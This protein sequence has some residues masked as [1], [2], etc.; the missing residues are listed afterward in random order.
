MWSHLQDVNVSG[1][2]YLST[3]RAFRTTLELDVSWILNGRI[4]TFSASVKPSL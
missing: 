1:D 2:S 3:K 4:L